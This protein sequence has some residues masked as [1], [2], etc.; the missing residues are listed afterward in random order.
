MF[1]NLK[2][3]CHIIQ[4]TSDTGMFT[5]FADKQNEERILGEKNYFLFAQNTYRN[6]NETEPKPWPKN[7]GTVSYLYRRT[8]NVYS[9]VHV[10]QYE[11]T[12]KNMLN[13]IFFD[14]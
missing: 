5:I 9:L 11:L 3:K 6:W 13:Y 1:S 12:F 7:Q 14:I 10:S 4:Y 8:P 2:E